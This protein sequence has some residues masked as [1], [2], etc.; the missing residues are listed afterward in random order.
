[1]NKV[2]TYKLTKDVI[3]AFATHPGIL[4]RDEIE[5]RNIKQ[6]KLAEELGIATTV[7]SE[8]IHGKRNIS[9]E[10][11]LKLE[12][13]L[14]IDALLWMRLQVKFD[15]DNLRIKQRKEALLP[16]QSKLPYSDTIVAHT[17][18]REPREKYKTK[19]IKKTDS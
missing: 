8:L 2:K 7:L 15:V 5:Y 19:K 6:K 17:Y 9:P 18:A 14:D 1:M 10:I 4:L 13:V 11:A 12:K 3:P 16:V